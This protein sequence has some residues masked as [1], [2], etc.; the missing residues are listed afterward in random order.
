MVQ[1]RLPLDGMLVHHSIT[2]AVFSRDM[3]PFIHLISVRECEEKVS[4]LRKQQYNAET[5]LASNQQHSD[6]PM[7]KVRRVNHNSTTSPPLSD[8]TVC[9][10]LITEELF[11]FLVF[12][13][14][15]S[16]GGDVYWRAA[17]FKKS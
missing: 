13:M 6:H 12:R 9:T 8:S 1:Q 17:L 5:N 4:C 2:M 3:Y 10:R 7:E 11:K 15:R 14:R 16:F